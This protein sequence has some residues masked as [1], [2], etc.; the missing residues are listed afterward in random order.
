MPAI[1]LT[2][3]SPFSLCRHNCQREHFAAKSTPTRMVRCQT[4][5]WPR[6]N[7]RV[8]FCVNAQ[9]ALIR[10]FAS[11]DVF[12]FREQALLCLQTCA[13]FHKKHVCVQTRFNIFF[14]HT[15]NT[16]LHRNQHTALTLSSASY[17]CDIAYLCLRIATGNTIN[18][19]RVYM[20]TMPTMP[21][22]YHYVR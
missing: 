19:Q 17:L 16:R 12:V 1:V 9:R 22:N 20:P 4:F 3:L 8:A 13:R 15:P 18:S 5:T 14:S 2:T 11:R 6:Y 7:K 21:T 10:F